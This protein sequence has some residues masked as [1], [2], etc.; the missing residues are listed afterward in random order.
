MVVKT[1]GSHSNDFKDFLHVK[2]ID[3]YGSKLSSLQKR[4][5]QMFFYG[6]NAMNY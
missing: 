2:N 1:K 3:D 5:K 6:L 4:S